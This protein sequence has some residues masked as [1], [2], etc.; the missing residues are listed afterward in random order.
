MQ[1]LHS[2][3]MKQARPLLWQKIAEI[4]IDFFLVL[5]AFLAAYF[6]RIGSF[7]ST[8]FPFLP[9][10]TLAALLSPVFLLLLAS[11]E[12]YSLREK[13]TM[14]F[15]R[16]ILLGTLVGVMTFVLL[17]FFKREFFFSR[18]MILYIWIFSFLFLF[19]FHIFRIFQEK[20][21]HRAKKGILRTL[22]IGNG[23]A[24][25]HIAQTLEKEGSRFQVVAALA[26]YGGSR[27][28]VHKAPVLGKMDALERVTSEKK[29]DAII[30]TEA[31]EHTLN[32]VLFAEGRFLDFL[33]A[34]QI[35]GIFHQRFLAHRIAGMPFLQMN[36]SP[37]FGWGQVWKRLFDLFFSLIFTLLLSPFLLFRSQ[38]KKTMASG[39]KEQIFTTKEFFHG[40]G[41]F[42]YLPEILS[43]LRG[44]MSLV[45]PRP[46]SPEERSSLSLFER[47]RLA[48]KPGIFGRWQLQKIKGAKDNL[49][50]EVKAD[51]RYISEWSFSGDIFLLFQ[52]VI[53]LFSHKK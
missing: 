28:M 46:R 22:I 31:V 18:L 29:I 1:I 20:R 48:V 5:F 27:K 16:I 44:D 40:K 7:S 21:R 42:R 34:P 15:A 53:A 10:I 13:N 43:V 26:P 50:Q 3:Q 11:S 45:G 4:G 24:A 41:F 33:I 47:Q 52:S 32:L 9:Y 25:E 19:S 35:I 6:L 2:L 23:R 38:I 17:F 37:L 36:V 8:N 49:Q 30:Q 39:P 12:L 14:E 51:T